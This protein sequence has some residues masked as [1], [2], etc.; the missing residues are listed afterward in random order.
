MVQS[1]SGGKG[2]HQGKQTL[3]LQADEL[4]PQVNVPH[5]GEITVFFNVYDFHDDA[6]FSAGLPVPRYAVFAFFG[7]TLIA[8]LFFAA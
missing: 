1:H 6:P 2:K 5:V 7:K 3:G 8:P 4:I